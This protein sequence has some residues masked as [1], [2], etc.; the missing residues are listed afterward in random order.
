MPVDHEKLHENLLIA[1]YLIGCTWMLLATWAGIKLRTWWRRR[2]AIKRRTAMLMQI[3]YSLGVPYEEMSRQ[4]NDINSGPS[5][6]GA[7]PPP[8]MAHYEGPVALRPSPLKQ[9]RQARAARNR[10]IVLILT[11][12]VAATALGTALAYDPTPR[13]HRVWMGQD[14]SEVRDGVSYISLAACQD[15]GARPAHG[16]IRCEED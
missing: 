11:G 8:T 15:I 6:L 9:L 10:T 7:S 1:G 13:F 12:I 5:R 2:Q 4:W 16:F 14:G 3:G